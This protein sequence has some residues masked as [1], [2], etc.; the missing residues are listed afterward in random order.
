MLVEGGGE[1][2]VSR[3]GGSNSLV[4]EGEGQTGC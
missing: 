4:V 1:Q 2:N 3:G